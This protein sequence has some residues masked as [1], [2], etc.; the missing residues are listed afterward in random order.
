MIG[1]Y[2][3]YLYFTNPDEEVALPKGVAE[4]T[5]C[6]PRRMWKMIN[7]RSFVSQARLTAF[8]WVVVS[9][10]E[11]YLLFHWEAG[12]PNSVHEVDAFRY[13]KDHFYRYSP[14]FSE[15][16]FA[17]V[18]VG[19]W[20]EPFYFM[21]LFPRS[22]MVFAGVAV[23]AIR[24]APL[25]SVRRIALN[26]SLGITSYL[27][28]TSAHNLQ[29]IILCLLVS[30]ECYKLQERC[31]EYQDKFGRTSNDERI[32]QHQELGK[33]MTTLGDRIH[34]II[35][36]LVSDRIVHMTFDVAL[37]NCSSLP[38]TRLHYFFRHLVRILAVFLMIWRIGRLNASIYDDL[39]GK[40]VYE[41]VCAHQRHADLDTDQFTKK[42]RE[43]KDWI[44]YLQHNGNG[45][46]KYCLRVCHYQCCLRSHT[47]A[48][49]VSTVVLIP[50]YKKL[51]AMIP[52]SY[53]F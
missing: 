53:F 38:F 15:W 21:M 5:M 3:G 44:L 1:L 13:S 50:F 30:W 9:I 35:M 19:S 31:E 49:W 32:K 48:F 2:L 40:V 12:V 22:W 4:P 34:P 7:S 29:F 28:L 14:D 45:K 18:V 11:C 51:F 52:E 41:L 6:M 47:V 36:Y 8:A 26:A 20:R 39:T 46:R 10:S 33:A 43:L 17:R 16:D 24:F 27:V 37:W 23:L 42:R 25:P